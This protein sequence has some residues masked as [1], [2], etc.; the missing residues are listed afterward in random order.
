MNLDKPLIKL[1]VFDWAGTAVDFGS[2]A[3]AAAFKSVFAEH[4][5]E[6]TD[7]EARAP[8]GLNK[9]QH[10]ITMLDQP[11]VDALWKSVHG[12]AWNES[13]VDQMYHEFMPLQMKTIALHSEPVSGLI[14]AVSELRAMGCKIAGTTGYF[15]EA[16]AAVAKQ[17]AAAGF[18]PDA[19]VCADDVVQGRPAPWMIYHAMEQTEVYPPSSVL[20]LGDTVADI[21]AGV[22]AGCW[23]V[24]VCD[25]SSIMGLASEGYFDLPD[26]QRAAK[27]QH[28]A[29]TFQSVGSHATIATIS[30]LPALVRKINTLQGD[31]PRFIDDLVCV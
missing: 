31:G 20:N 21:Q 2:Q 6:V 29:K 11:R 22:N 24:G 1:V 18:Q 27:L 16:A 12:R 19:N 25:S 28:V 5:V 9:R 23:S 26:Q 10:L 7:A 15:R 30:Q 13:D 8:M 14:D 17:A 3:P 4:G